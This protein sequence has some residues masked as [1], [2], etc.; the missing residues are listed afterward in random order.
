MQG[1]R[2]PAPMQTKTTT[3]QA[4]ESKHDESKDREKTTN[5]TK[6]GWT[7]TKETVHLHIHSFIDLVAGR[8]YKLNCR[9][10]PLAR[11]SGGFDRHVRIGRS[12]EAGGQV[13]ERKQQ[14]RIALLVTVPKGCRNGSGYAGSIVKLTSSGTFRPASPAMRLVS[15]IELT[16]LATLSD[17]P[18]SDANWATM[19]LICVDEGGAMAAV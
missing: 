4:G 15:E 3:I 11:P 16:L 14:C 13:Q 17:S 6:T 7:A 1:S 2:L 18:V 19:A 8:F 12:P 9:T 10:P 5:A